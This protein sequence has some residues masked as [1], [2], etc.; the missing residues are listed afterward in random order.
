MLS[1][2]VV[3]RS[4]Q[5]AQHA[6]RQFQRGLVLQ[7]RI[8]LGD[9]QQDTLFVTNRRSART[10]NNLELTDIRL[11]VRE[12]LD[13]LLNQLGACL[14]C[15]RCDW[16]AL[17]HK[18]LGIGQGHRESRLCGHSNDARFS[19]HG[20]YNFHDGNSGSFSMSGKHRV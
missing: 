17:H 6:E 16:T 2:I 18:Y 1:A 8:L 20:T 11:A 3:H 12:R 4:L 19:G 13:I 5:L 7:P 15:E 9:D 14:R 10:L